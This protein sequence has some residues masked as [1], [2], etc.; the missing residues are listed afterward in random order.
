MP[1]K[2][3]GTTRLT[4]TVETWV[5][6]YLELAAAVDGSSVAQ[7]IRQ[8]LRHEAATRRHTMQAMHDVLACSGSLPPRRKE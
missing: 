3:P 1:A 7:Q 6:E 4:F 8:I 2:N 5:T